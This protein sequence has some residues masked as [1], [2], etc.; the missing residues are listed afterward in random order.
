V[1][2]LPPRVD[3]RHAAKI[4]RHLHERY[5]SWAPRDEIGSGVLRGNIPAA[6]VEHALSDL[7]AKR[8]IERRQVPTEGRP[9]E[10]YR[11]IAPQ[12]TLFP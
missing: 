3:P 1:A 6:D 2:Q 9:R 7:A 12:L 10:E 11:L 8:L 4:F 5:P